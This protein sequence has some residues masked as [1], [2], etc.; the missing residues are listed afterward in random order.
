MG[1]NKPWYWIGY[2]IANYVSGTSSM[3]S[4][5]MIAVVLINVT[6]LVLG[7]ISAGV[8]MYVSY[9]S[10]SRTGH[11]SAGPRTDSGPVAALTRWVT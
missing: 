10:K 3:S 8:E 7:L 9:F 6:I 4:F 1:F 11:P 5:L 2:V